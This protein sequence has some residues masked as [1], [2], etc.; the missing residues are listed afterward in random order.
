M[1]STGAVVYFK[2]RA[3]ISVAAG[4]KTGA[5][6]Y[7]ASRFV[8]GLY[9]ETG[10]TPSANLTGLRARKPPRHVPLARLDKDG[11]YYITE[12]WDRYLEHVDKIRLGGPLGPN[13]P[14]I[15]T[16]VTTAQAQAATVAAT[17]AGLTQQVAQ[18]A[19]SLAATVE[20]AENNA[21][22]GATQIPRVQRT[23]GIEP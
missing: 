10:V 1:A 22:T 19:E 13:L 21:L 14:D 6:V 4:R 16:T 17:A 8:S 3:V 7:V 15:E 12:A 20:V 5:V 9:S 2:P 18:N 11:N 23:S